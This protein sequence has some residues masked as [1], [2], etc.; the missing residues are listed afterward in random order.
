MG[1]IVISDACLWIAN[2]C[3]RWIYGNWSRWLGR[4][5]RAIVT[6]PADVSVRES[7][8]LAGD[9]PGGSVHLVRMYPTG[10][11]QVLGADLPGGRRCREGE[12]GP[13]GTRPRIPECIKYDRLDGECCPACVEFGCKYNGTSYKR[14][15]TIVTHDACRKCYC[16]W[17]GETRGE[18]VCLELHCPPVNCVDPP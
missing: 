13:G 18:P 17:E 2:I 5:R 4:Y 8:L 16:P 12:P 3:C 10:G 15:S 1:F 11:Y 14:G 9:V 7:D 6:D